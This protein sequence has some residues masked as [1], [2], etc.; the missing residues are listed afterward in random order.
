MLGPNSHQFHQSV[1]LIVK[2]HPAKPEEAGKNLE[3]KTREGKE[4]KRDKDMKREISQ[5]L[6]RLAA[7]IDRKKY[8]ECTHQNKGV[9]RNGIKSCR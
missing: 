2:T 9:V 7:E 3:R 6:L 5:Q 8:F 4:G 1:F